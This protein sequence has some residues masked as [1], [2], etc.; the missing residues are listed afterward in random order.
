MNK[1]VELRGAA[2]VIITTTCVTFKHEFSKSA[3]RV[4]CLLVTLGLELQHT[5]RFTEHVLGT[6]VKIERLH[7]KSNINFVS[8]MFKYLTEFKFYSCKFSRSG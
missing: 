7:Y 8:A 5:V 6:I 4:F 2:L 3:E 1:L